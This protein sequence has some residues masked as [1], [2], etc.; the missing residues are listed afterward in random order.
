MFGR[1]E[2]NWKMGRNQI[3]GRYLLCR[4]LALSF[5]V[6]LPPEQGMRRASLSAWSWNGGIGVKGAF[7][8]RSLVRGE[9]RL[10]SPGSLLWV[11][12]LWAH[13]FPA[14][15]DFLCLLLFHTS[16]VS[17]DDS[18]LSY[19]SSLDDSP[20]QGCCKSQPIFC[21]SGLSY[22]SPFGCGPSQSPSHPHSQ[23]PEFWDGQSWWGKS[24]QLRIVCFES[25]SSFNIFCSRNLIMYIKCIAEGY[26]L[27][28][29]ECIWHIKFDPLI[30][31]F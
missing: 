11:T 26:D 9:F 12:L 27:L 3:I 10:P 16:D 23:H 19:F 22:P 25:H 14:K 31:D 5:K 17:D 21:F 13:L 8:S 7:R 20:G 24:S 15:R 6:F 29:Q 1:K 2:M 30:V 18:L 4:N 28:K